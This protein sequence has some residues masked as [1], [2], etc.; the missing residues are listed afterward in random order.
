M[1]PPRGPLAPALL[2][3]LLLAGCT[4]PGGPPGAPFLGGQ[5][6]PLIAGGWY[7]DCRIASANW[8]DP[9]TARATVTHGPANE[10]MLAV[11]PTD[12][13]NVVIGAKDYTPE[14]SDCVWAGTAVT[15][16]AGATWVNG[17]VGGSRSEREPRVQAYDCV[18]DP[19]LEFGPDGLLYYLVEAYNAASEA[20]GALPLNQTPVGGF[21]VGSNMWLAVSSDGGSTWEF[22]GQIS[23]GP[24]GVI[25]LHD[26]SD[27]AVSPT[28]GTIVASWTAFSALAS[29][30]LYTRST[31]GGN[32]FSPPRPLMTLDSP[33]QAQETT[34]MV[35]LDF[36]RS[37][38]LH[39][40]WFNWNTGDVLYAVS[41]DDGATFT[42]PVVLSPGAP[43]T[44]A[45]APNSNFRI[46]DSTMLAVDLTEGNRSGWLYVTWADDQ[47]SEGDHDVWFLRSPDGGLTWTSPVQVNS[48]TGTDQ[49]HPN[50]AVASDG[51]VHLFM[52]DRQ[53][54]PENRL[55]DVTHGISLDGG[56]SWNWT[57][58]S[59]AS[60]DG[61]LGI[62]Q[63]G[64]PFM[65]DYNG[66]AAG[67]GVVY[68]TYADTREGRSDI[69][70]AKF[71]LRG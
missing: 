55:L 22:R 13:G 4:A 31:D 28:T 27:L 71:V 45:N 18:T 43:W 1:L 50:L 46:F 59:N 32:V 54:D 10:L 66:I 53:Y 52:Y 57:R 39:A 62:H 30:L 56:D 65:G 70:V 26:K 8:S 51:S 23:L 58:V 63:S 24:G 68:I 6:P 34:A 5:G 38:R 14:G 29:Q 41:E 33:A 2:L 49:F 61:D 3:C 35:D 7:Q 48:F 40:V 64:V 67:E 12:S 20:T 15:R 47:L 21:G 11:N 16:D 36:D 37:G 9:C 19:V 17:W 44:G 42:A 60:F 69:A 25:L